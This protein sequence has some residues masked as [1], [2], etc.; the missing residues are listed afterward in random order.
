MTSLLPATLV[1]NI[2]YEQLCVASDCPKSWLNGVKLTFLWSGP[3]PQTNYSMDSS[4][5]DFPIPL[6][7]NFNSK[8]DRGGKGIKRKIMFLFP[9]VPR[10]NYFTKKPLNWQRFSLRT[11][12]SNSHLFLW[13]FDRKYFLAYIV[14]FQHL[15]SRCLVRVTGWYFILY[16]FPMMCLV[17]L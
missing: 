8:V 15:R 9:S 16:F 1:P 2:D 17:F 5:K 4:C 3:S 7:T 6:H 10:C 12:S 11:Y 13:K 14:L